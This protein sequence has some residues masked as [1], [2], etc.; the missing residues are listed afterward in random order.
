M[1]IK[2]RFRRALRKS[3]SSSSLSQSDTNTT[4]TTTTTNTSQSS[5]PA[6]SQQSHSQKAPAIALSKTFTWGNRDKDKEREKQE[7][8][9]QK[10]KQRRGGPKPMHPSEKPLTAQNLKHQEMLGH[11]TM[12]FGATNRSEHGGFGGVSPCCTR[13]ASIADTDE[14]GP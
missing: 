9:E 3:D 8:R 1:S 13:P 7:K 5:L 4:T 10:K 14:Y 6:L 11:F 2:D 12:T